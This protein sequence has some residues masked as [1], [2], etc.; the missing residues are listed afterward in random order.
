MKRVV[1]V[2]IGFVVGI[3]TLVGAPV[4]SAGGGPGCT[5]TGTSGP[6]LLQGTG[7]NDVICGLGGN[8]RIFAGDGNDTVRA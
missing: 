8:D 1:S 4:A 3:A 7:G 6:D 2:G 5:I